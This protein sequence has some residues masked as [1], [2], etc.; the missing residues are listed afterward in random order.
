MNSGFNVGNY[1]A[2][3]DLLMIVA[4]WL[5]CFGVTVVAEALLLPAFPDAMSDPM[6]LRCIAAAKNVIMLV[7]PALLLNKMLTEVSSGNFVSSINRPLTLKMLLAGVLV[8]VALVP[9]ISSLSL[10]NHQLLPQ[11]GWLHDIAVSQDASVN[12]YY[13]LVMTSR[14]PADW[15]AN[16]VVVALLAGVGE[17]LFFRG[18]LQGFAVRCGMRGWVAVFVVA[19]L[20]SLVHFQVSEFIP[21]LAMGVVLGFAYL[22]T[23]RIWMPVVVHVV[24][25]VVALVTYNHELSLGMQC[26]VGL[27]AVAGLAAVLRLGGHKK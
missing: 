16:I 21:R 27:A 2:P 26:L 17:E 4:T 24:N 6:A 19:L 9:A 25:N 11:S 18:I 12:A 22:K 1:N 8:T 7:L 23:G 5:A 10:L 14:V 20:F 15:I 3:R 13:A